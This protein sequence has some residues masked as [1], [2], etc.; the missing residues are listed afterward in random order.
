[1]SNRNLSAAEIAHNLY[2]CKRA[3]QQDAALAKANSPP[4]KKAA[5]AFPESI[6][7]ASQTRHPPGT[8]RRSIID[9]PDSA[10]SGEWVRPLKSYRQRGL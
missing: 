8:A 2:A 1:M 3:H 4:D 6:C 7:R 5:S 10:G 9:Q